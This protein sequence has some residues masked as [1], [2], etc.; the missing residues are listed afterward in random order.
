MAAVRE[1]RKS[2]RDVHVNGSGE[3]LFEIDRSKHFMF[4]LKN[5]YLNKYGGDPKGHSPTGI[6]GIEIQQRKGADLVAALNQRL[7]SEKHFIP[8]QKYLD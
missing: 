5:N 8:H 6:T 1:A 3:K 7:S 2:V 4:I